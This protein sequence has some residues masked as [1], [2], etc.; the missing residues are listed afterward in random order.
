MT[1]SPF[2]DTDPDRIADIARGICAL[3]D[4]C[5]ATHAETFGAMAT[6][7]SVRLD[8]CSPRERV[9]VAHLL[10]DA[11]CSGGDMPEAGHA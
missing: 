7:M 2:A 10:A 4:V 3:L 8:G 11:I 5:Q 9:F 6:A 1:D